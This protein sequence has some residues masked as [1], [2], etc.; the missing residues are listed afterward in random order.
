MLIF[1]NVFYD[2]IFFSVRK[3]HRR[4]TE[5]SHHSCAGESADYRSF[6]QPTG[7]IIYIG[8]EYSKQQEVELKKITSQGGLYPSS[9]SSLRII[10]PFLDKRKILAHWKYNINLLTALPLQQKEITKN[11]PKKIG[12]CAKLQ[13]LILTGSNH[14]NDESLQQIA[15]GN[16]TAPA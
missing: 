6:V 14:F 15:N 10:F 16:N 9:Y 1:T 13:Q 11:V 2:F 7:N 8:H 12:N 4:S 3:D 5:R